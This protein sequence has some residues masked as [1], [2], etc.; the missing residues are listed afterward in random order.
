MAWENASA[1]IIIGFVFLFM[2][3]AT[4]IEN[5][6]WFIKILFFGLG[7]GTALN[8]A[9]FMRLILV[10]NAV[11]EELISR[12]ETQYKILIWAIRMFFAGI[13]IMILFGI[14]NYFK[15][16]GKTFQKTMRRMNDE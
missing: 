11:S 14:Y 5:K 13:G 15:G 4:I 9:E 8:G 3:F 6:Y 16:V 10:E 12:A 1:V 7:L 2:Y